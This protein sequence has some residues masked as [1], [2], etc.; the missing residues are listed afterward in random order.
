MITEHRYVNSLWMLEQI[1]WYSSGHEFY[2]G[3]YPWF[4]YLIRVNHSFP[5][6]S[7]NDVRCLGQKASTSH[8]LLAS[9]ACLNFFFL[10]FFFQT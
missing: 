5:A 6:G 3:S 10:H 9:F 1:Q 7:S 2:F 8:Y 4:E